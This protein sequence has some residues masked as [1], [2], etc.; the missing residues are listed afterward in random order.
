MLDVI[1]SALGAILILFMI[2]IE[3]TS[4]TEAQNKK[5]QEAL[6]KANVTVDELSKELERLAK[7]DKENKALKKKLKSSSAEAAGSAWGSVVCP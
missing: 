6:K 2:T 5:T 3:Y 4:K 1:F 7:L